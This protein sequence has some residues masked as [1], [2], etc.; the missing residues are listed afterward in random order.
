MAHRISVSVAGYQR[1]KCVHTKGI[2]AFDNVLKNKI[3]SQL[4]FSQEKFRATAPYHIIGFWDNGVR[5]FSNRVRS[6]KIPEDCVG[7]KIRTQMGP[8]TW[9]GFKG[10]RL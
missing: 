10:I 7:L 2:K 4:N 3:N 1:A 9:Q 5:H 8:L 6:I